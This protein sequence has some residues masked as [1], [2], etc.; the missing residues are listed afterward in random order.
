VSFERYKS[1][2][3]ELPVF[4]LPGLSEEARDRLIGSYPAENPDKYDSERVKY[5]LRSHSVMWEL[6]SNPLILTLI[7]YLVDDPEGLELPTTRAKLY[8]GVFKKL[9][10]RSRVQVK[11]PGEPPGVDEKMAVLER[12]AFG[13]FEAGRLLTFKRRELVEQMKTALK[14]E[15]YTSDIPVWAGAFVKDFT[16]NAGVI[17][18]SGDG[19]CFFL[20]PTLHEYLTASWIARKINTEGWESRVRF[21]GEEVSLKKF[22]SRKAWDPGWEEVILLLAGSLED[23]GPLLEMLSDEKP[24]EENPYGDDFFRHRLGLA[25]L[26]LGELGEEQKGKL[27]DKLSVVTAKVFGGWYKQGFLQTLQHMEKALKSLARCN[28]FVREGDWRRWVGEHPA[29]GVDAPSFLDWVAKMVEDP[30]GRFVAILAVGLMGGSA[31]RPDV[32]SLFTELLKDEDANTRRAA[33]LASMG[34]GF[35]PVT[36]EIFLQIVELLK[37]EDGYVRRAA[38][39]AVGSIGSSAAVPEFLDQIAKLLEDKRA[40][41]RDA[42]VEA[43]GKMGSTAATTEILSRIAKLL[44]DRDSYVRYAAASAVGEM[45][46]TAATTEILSRI[47]KLLEDEDDDVRYAA[48]SAVGEM[49][50]TAA[51]IEILSRIAELLKDER[52]Y[53]CDVAIW[54]VVEMGSTAATTEFLS[55]IAK[56]L[57]DRDWY[58]R[59]AAI[60]AVGKMGST[61]ATT[62]ILSRIAKL[63]E[64]ERWYVRDAAAEAVEAMGIRLFRRGSTLTAERL[65]TLT[66]PTR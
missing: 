22:V 39:E 62:E 10:G 30:I 54:A 56:L 1:V 14:E 52:G 64:D 49:D 43:V 51:R 58:A 50:S 38:A 7:C 66:D 6:A 9:L 27:G 4:M 11:Y 44:E 3:G 26:C 48:A 46:S 55:Q 41:V 25:G 12:A 21:G 28:A 37:D 63:L 24:T 5:E 23:A 53:V 13:L 45:G 34:L 17:R 2:C 16:E 18:S 47:A 61:A 33:T 31:A 32:L 8:E 36:R 42:A 57:E 35:S 40:Y 59:D 15:G 29:V 20:H 65:A 60:W 19:M